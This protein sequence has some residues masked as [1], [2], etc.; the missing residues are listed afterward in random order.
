MNLTNFNDER[1]EKNV[2]INNALPDFVN[3]FINDL[4]N[5]LQGKD[6]NIL[7]EDK[8]YV[9]S[10]IS[11]NS[12]NVVDIENGDEIKINISTEKENIKERNLA[13]YQMEK[14]EFMKLNLTDNVVLKDNMLHPN[15]DKIEIRSDKA[16]RILSDLYMGEKETEGKEYRVVDM[17]NDKAY[18]TN[19]DGSGGYFSVYKELYPDFKVGDIVKKS[20]REYIKTENK[21]D[22]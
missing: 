20:N 1:L 3:D 9:V 19:A 12:I 15:N 7:K 18:L 13:T 5:Y 14:T 4:S 2:S 11:G 22:E 17:K 8:T 16:W 6:V 10:N 21:I